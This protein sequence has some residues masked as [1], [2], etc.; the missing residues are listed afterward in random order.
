MCECVCDMSWKVIRE[1]WMCYTEK[2]N[3]SVAVEAA[4]VQVIEC[5]EWEGK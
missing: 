3:M 4:A 5:V 2:L 1:A